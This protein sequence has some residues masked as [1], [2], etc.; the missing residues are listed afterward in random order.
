[1]KRLTSRATILVVL[2]V[3][4]AILVTRPLVARAE[5][6]SS[7]PAPSTNPRDSARFWDLSIRPFIGFD[8]NVQLVPDASFFDGD[9]SSF[10]GGLDVDGSLRFFENEHWTVAAAASLQNVWYAEDQPDPTP[11]VN[12]DHDDYD[13]AAVHPTASVGYRDVIAG[14]PVRIG[15]SY[16]FRFEDGEVHAIGLEAH[17]FG[18]SASA[19]LTRKLA[20]TLAYAH[21]WNRF[22]V[23][24]PSNSL[25]GRDSDLDRVDVSARYRFD[26]GRR[27]ITIGYGFAK[28]DADGSNFDYEAHQVSAKLSSHLIASLWGQVDFSARIADYDGPGFG[29]IPVRRKEQE[30]FGYGVALV[31]VF[32]PNLSADAF[33]R[34]QDIDS[35]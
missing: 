22:D 6:E 13:L 11:G 14:K 23:S 5:F 4:V 3:P 34:R 31:W 19:D 15:T 17:T 35:N 7:T 12:D 2:I 26:R 32:C 21:E 18:L 28:N 10:F 30:V 27:S 1:M 33:Y 20:V 16:A 8:D 24:F 9:T 29:F 25:N